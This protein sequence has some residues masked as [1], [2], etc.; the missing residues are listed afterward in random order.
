MKKQ[1]L[2]QFY[3]NQLFA[4]EVMLLPYYI[5]SLNVEH[6]YFELTGS[7]EPFEGICFVDT[8]DLAG[9]AQ[10]LFAMTEANTARVT[11][12][13]RTPITLI[14]GNPPYNVGQ[15]NENDNNKNRKYDIIDRRIKATYAKGSKATSVS[16]LNDPYV[17]FFRWATDRLEGR[18]GI[19]CFVTNNSF[20]DQIA[21][22]SMRRDLLA[23]FTKVYHVHLEGNVR[24][25][26]KLS[27]NAFNVFGIQV[28]VGITV[29]IRSSRH[30][31]HKLRFR[32]LDKLLRRHEKLAWLA[33]MRS[34]NLTDWQDLV[35]DTNH[36]W[37]LAENA[38]EFADLP[39]IASKADK[40]AHDEDVRAIFK[41]YTL[42]VATHR[43]AVVYDFSRP[44]LERRVRKFIENYNGEVD[45]FRRSQGKVN[46]DQFVNYESVVWDRDLKSDLQRGA[47][48]EFDTTKIRAALYRPFT[49]RFLFFDRLLNAEIYSIPRVF[50]TQP[51]EMENRIVWLKVGSEWP[52][53]PLVA[54][55][56]VD[57]L[58]QGGSQ[59]FPFYTYDENGTNRRENI[60][61]WA[62]NQFRTH[63]KN[64]RID[65]WDIFHYVYGLLHHP[66]YRERYAD[67]LK[68]ELPR[69]PFA[70]DFKSFAKAGKQLAEL[71]LGYE[72]LDPWELD[73]IETPGVPLSYRVERM[74]LAKDKRSLQVNDSLTLGGIPPQVSDYRL[75][76]RSALE[77][78]VDQY[79][80]KTDQRSGIT[81]DP[82]K[83]DDPEYITRLIGQVVRVSVETVRI[84]NGLPDDFGAPAKSS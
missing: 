10:D 66:G 51:T 71:H 26:P 57:L 53:F 48:G 45:R 4:N 77:W 68:R 46:I 63:Y 54:R 38:D 32:R 80:V 35:P 37:L 8:L 74:K 49:K 55:Q 34:I 40:R 33:A 27:G 9:A 59:C 36:T 22:D 39:P 28:G 56:I 43:D 75:G 73:W 52:M 7:Y 64:K 5:A 6:A 44:E 12:Q 20:V 17:K 84:V 50:P 62:L 30:R 15:L 70:P 1:L 24:H 41:L 13:K 21:F 14:I 19:V 23:E 11:R 79:R 16:K 31:K 82:N 61:D 83:G 67:S 76:N 29:A 3:R 25:N 78:V 47:Y 60:T 69:I 72:D 58:P 65:K 42:G 81:S 2:P 18:D